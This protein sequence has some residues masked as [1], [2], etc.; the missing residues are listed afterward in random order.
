MA[1]VGSV[2]VLFRSVASE[3]SADPG[4]ASY[5]LMARLS[6]NDQ[7]QQIF[8]AFKGGALRLCPGN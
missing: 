5:L 4:P 2:A 3:A 6:R 8:G 1:W 7:S